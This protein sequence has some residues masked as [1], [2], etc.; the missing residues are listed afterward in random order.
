MGEEV[1]TLISEKLPSGQYKHLWNASHLASGIYI[2]KIQAD[3]YVM[4]RKMMLIK[5]SD[6]KYYFS[7]IY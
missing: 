1:A 5:L 6:L 4:T 7:V 3:Q 2:Y